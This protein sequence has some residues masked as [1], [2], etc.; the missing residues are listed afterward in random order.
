[1]GFPCFLRFCCNES[2]RHEPK[3]GIMIEYIKRRKTLRVSGWYD[4]IVS[5]G[6]EE[7]SLRDFFGFL[8][9]TLK[10][11]EKVFKEGG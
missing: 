10:D 3:E 4:T 11:C 5:M 2:M 1:M 8:D 9:I 6:K 7:M